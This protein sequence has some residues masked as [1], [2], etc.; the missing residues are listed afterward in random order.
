MLELTGVDAVTPVTCG[1]AALTTGFEYLGVALGVA[2]TL[3]VGAEDTGVS[4]ALAFGKLL[5]VVAGVVAVED[6]SAFAC[7]AD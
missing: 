4:A 7:D 6:A 1:L 5:R 2:A 3:G